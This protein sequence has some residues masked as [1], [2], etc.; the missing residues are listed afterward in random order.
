MPGNKEALHLLLKG[1]LT[2][3]IMAIRTMLLLVAI[4]A[5]TKDPIQMQV[6]IAAAATTTATIA[7]NGNQGNIIKLIW[8]ELV[9][10][11]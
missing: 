7:V 10:V 4:T 3:M 1:I 2:T 5:T 6:T 11:S 9:P 8:W